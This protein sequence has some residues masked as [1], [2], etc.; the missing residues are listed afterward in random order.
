MVDART[1]RVLGWG[2]VPRLL[3]SVFRECGVQNVL[4]AASQHSK[5]KVFKFSGS[6]RSFSP[7]Q[8]FYSEPRRGQAPKEHLPLKSTWARGHKRGTRSVNERTLGDSAE[9]PVVRA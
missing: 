4:H 5:E 7:S 6:F 9:T 3:L 8:T 1:L 2:A